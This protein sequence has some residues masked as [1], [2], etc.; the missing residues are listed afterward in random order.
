MPAKNYISEKYHQ[1]RERRKSILVHSIDF[2]PSSNPNE[3]GDFGNVG[4]SKEWTTDQVLNLFDIG[5]RWALEDLKKDIAK[6]I[7]D[8]QTNGT[9]KMLASE[10]EKLLEDR[11]QT[12]FYNGKEVGIATDETKIEE[13]KNAFNKQRNHV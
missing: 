3:V 11:I 7:K 12:T 4:D 10:V 5:Y 6:L 13:R 1:F 8:S 2:Y 9:F